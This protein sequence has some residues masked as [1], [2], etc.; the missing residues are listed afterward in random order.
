[1]AKIAAISGLKS[2]IDWSNLVE[3]IVNAK[4]AYFLS[5]VSNEKTIYERKLS[6]WQQFIGRI[7]GVLDFIRESGLAEKNGYKSYTYKISSSDPTISPESALDIKMGSNPQKGTYDLQILSLAQKEKISSDQIYSKTEPLLLSGRISI[8]GVEIQVQS[9]F[10]LTDLASAINSSDAKVEA[11]IL[12]IDS[13]H[14]RLLLES[15]KEGSSGISLSDPD[16][17]L[18]SLG[19]LDEDGNKKNVIRDG[20]DASILF[21]G[22]EIVSSSNTFTDLIP[23][24]TLNLKAKTTPYTLNLRIEEDTG[25]LEKK[26]EELI[27]RINS[28]LSFIQTQNTYSEGKNNPLIGDTNLSAVRNC[29]VK[30]VY[31][32]ES[33]NG[34]FKTL[35]SIGIVFQRDG[36]LKIDRTVFLESLSKGRDEVIRVL[37]NFADTLLTRFN[38]LLDPYSG[39][40]KK[41][42]N[43]IESQLR[44][45]GRRMKEIEERFEKERELLE[46]RYTQLELL[47]SQSSTI[48]KWMENQI[49]AIYKRV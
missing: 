18:K 1:M 9:D 27:S 15:E 38:P 6:S 32:E 40:Y 2:T 35:S 13:N 43:S 49:A 23:G 41:I 44:R 14:F 31:A 19:I 47:I 34:T 33:N 17:I 11:T 30:A 46:K 25:E 22:F 21:E 45:I 37:E 5:P 16:N 48:S 12:K 26:I 24:V 20:Q 8:N 28:L 10:T 42:E 3:K 29:I 36:L 39:T 7:K 4:K